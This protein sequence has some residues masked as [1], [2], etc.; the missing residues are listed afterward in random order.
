[1]RPRL[2]RHFADVPDDLLRRYARRLTNRPPSNGARI[3]EPLRTIESVYFLRYCLLIG[4]DRLLL[5]VRRRVADLWRH[6]TTDAN[7][8]L[9]H[10]AD[11]Y[12]ELLTSVAAL[13]SDTTVADTEVRD[14]LRSL[15]AE[16][17]Q[18]KPP[19]RAHLVRDHLTFEIRPLR[20]LLSALM[21]LPWEATPGH[22]VLAAI[23]LLRVLYEH[24]AR[25]LTGLEKTCFRGT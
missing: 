22:P 23:Q 6:A 24:D 10:W 4:T 15:V 9:I 16:H 19:T 14:R 8:V 17:R 3:K 1:V 2:H 21:V 7:R 20:S 5:M 13:A 12:R 25:E 18:R 11:L